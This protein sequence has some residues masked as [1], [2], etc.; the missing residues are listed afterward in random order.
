MTIDTLIKYTA[1]GLIVLFFSA[2]LLAE[3]NTPYNRLIAPPLNDGIQRQEN[4]C[5]PVI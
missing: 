2:F 3:L 1:I 4:V 5:K